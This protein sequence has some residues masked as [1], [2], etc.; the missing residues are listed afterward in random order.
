MNNFLRTT[1]L[2]VAISAAAPGVFAQ[3]AGQPE[4]P[5]PPA[6]AQPTPPTPAP[7]QPTPAPP[8]ATPAPAPTDTPPPPP[9][10]A[11]PASGYQPAQPAQPAT[12]PPPTG[13]NPPP[14]GYG[15][16]RYYE[17]P[18]PR[19]PQPTG[20][21]T[22]DGFYL[23]L[24]FG[25]GFFNDSITSETFDGDIDF[26]IRGFTTA[27]EF[28]LGGTVARGLVLGG[29]FLSGLV[30]APEAEVG[31]ISGDL[32][33]SLFFFMLGPFIDYYF[34]PNEGFHL[35]VLVGVAALSADD[36]DIDVAV[37]GGF[38]IGLGHEWWVADQWSIG[39]LGRLAFA[40]MKIDDSFLEE[41]HRAVQAAALFTATYH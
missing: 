10:T 2:T 30:P 19:P 26:T 16:Q 37:G 31:G 35:Q 18:P 4:P 39:I 9:T 40:S 7:A 23:R 8:A 1:V 12:A 5:P 17:P 6:P 3:P 28:M 38:G 36:E 29:G 14:P 41:Q 34:D 33:T 22:H 20:V 27:S 21:N 25:L 13:Y 32:D 11:P 15:E 24:A